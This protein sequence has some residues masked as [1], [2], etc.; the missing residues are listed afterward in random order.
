VKSEIYNDFM[1]VE[2]MFHQCAV[3]FGPSDIWTG[4]G[5]GLLRPKQCGQFSDDVVELLLALSPHLRQAFCLHL[6]FI[7]LRIH[8]AE[9]QLSLDALSAA[10]ISLDSRGCV[11]RYSSEAESLLKELRELAICNGHLKATNKHEN[12]RLQCLIANAI[13]TGSGSWVSNELGL[14]KV[15]C[16]GVPQARDRVFT[17][18]I[19]G[20]MLLSRREGLLPL[21]IIVF[22]LRAQH[23]FVG[24]APA[25]LIFLVDPEKKMTSRSSLLRSLY[26]LTPAECRLADLLMNGYELSQ[27][28][29]LMHVTVGTARFQLKS[30]FRKT[31]TARQTQLLRLLLRLPNQSVK[32][33]PS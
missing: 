21:Q 22:P 30:I 10:V 20:S 7:E 29:E 1:R 28:A 2:D 31:G 9:L 5:V 19:G 3:S 6:S 16:T 17:A 12:S 4:F 23:V 8:I 15:D 27:A 24:D 25:A 32:S 14:I 26:G 13:S 33:I 18:P 11:Q